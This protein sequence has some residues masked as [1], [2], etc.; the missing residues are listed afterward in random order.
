MRIA[1][2]TFALLAGLGV[3]IGHAWRE[4]PQPRV[5]D[6]GTVIRITF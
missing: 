6:L 4:P 5:D 3:V 2:L 1:L